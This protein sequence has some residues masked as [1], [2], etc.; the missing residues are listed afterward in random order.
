[1]SNQDNQ[2]NTSENTNVVEPTSVETVVEQTT[3]QETV[4]NTQNTSSTET[5]SLT[6]DSEMSS[7]SEKLRQRQINAGMSPTEQ[8]R[9]EM[10][11]EQEQ[12]TG[13]SN[14]A[15]QVESTVQEPVTVSQTENVSENVHTESG[16][17][18]MPVQEVELASARPM[19]SD[20]FVPDSMELYTSNI[21]L[22]LVI[23]VASTSI[24][25]KKVKT[26][27]VG[28]QEF[29][30]R[31][32]LARPVKGKPAGL[33]FNAL[34]ELL[35]TA[36]TYNNQRF[37]YA[38]DALTLE[39][40][41][42]GLCARLTDFV[43]GLDLAGGLSNESWEEQVGFAPSVSITPSF[44]SDELIVSMVV[45]FPLLS[46][47]PDKLETSAQVEDFIV[48]RIVGDS[49]I[50]VDVSYAINTVDAIIDESV[51]ELVN[52][53]IGESDYVLATDADLISFYASL[54][55]G[56]DED[57]DYSE[58]LGEDEDF[59][60][61]EDSDDDD[62]E[63]EGDDSD[64]SDEEDLESEGDEVETID[65]GYVL[66]NSL[67]GLEAQ[68]RYSNIGD[69]SFILVSKCVNELEDLDLS[70]AEQ[71]ESED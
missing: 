25:S 59:D 65:L 64:D 69:Q 58:D 4:N 35:S 29:N 1:M 19:F 67:A 62:L 38:G 44:D 2:Q 31:N 50:K 28:D 3:E 10:I 53:L 36:D 41:K 45:P 13:A 48:K 43:A 68:L 30:I 51:N 33:M 21:R 22:H 12:R 11:K 52:G 34:N 15:P 37:Y 18:E 20:L 39:N 5:E 57:F 71:E 42:S 27:E 40:M 26:I 8:A 46:M 56:E 32:T 47:T 70:G 14:P 49:N 6:K 54:E 17:P 24:L 7:E 66:H 63:A 61:D 55:E 23:P 60:S 9:E 16:L